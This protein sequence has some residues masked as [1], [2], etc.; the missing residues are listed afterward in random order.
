MAVT[1][2]EA[3]RRY[4]EDLAQRLGAGKVLRV[5]FLEGATYPDGEP[6]ATIAAANEFGRPENNQPP[7]PFFRQAINENRS[8][9]TKGFGVLLEQ[10]RPLEQA[11][12][13]T[14]EVMRGDIQAS[15]RKLT[16]PALAEATIARKGFDK[17]LIDTSHMLN[18]V[19]YEVRDD[20]PA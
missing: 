19:D 17:P 13:L 3:M 1:G 20:E 12:A 11:M 7:R 2:G 18:S 14:G 16:D 6:V 8:R 5:G 15:I 10:G 4:L 9:W